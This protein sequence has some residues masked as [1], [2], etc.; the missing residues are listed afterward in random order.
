MTKKSQNDKSNRNIH[1]SFVK[2]ALS[3]KTVAKEFF[4]TNLPQEILSQVDL[5]TLRQEKESYLDNTLG[6][7]IVDLI[8]S[9]KF[10]E[11]K[12]YLILLLEH[13]ST[14]D[15]KMPL[16]IQKYVLR[17]CDDWLKKNKGK[18]IPLIY[19]ILFYSGKEKYTA[20]LSFYSLFNNAEKAKEFLTKPIQIVETSKFQKEDIRSKY[21][22]GLMMYFMNKVHERDI[23]PFLKG[24]IEL[25]RKISEEGD[26]EYI[27]SMLYYVIEKADTEKVEGIF[28]EFKKAVTIKHQE[29]VMTIA[30]RLRE[31]GKEVG[32]QI[33]I[34]KGIEK[35]RQEG[36][37][38]VVT[39]MLLKKLDE[40]IIAESTGLTLEEIK[41]LKNLRRN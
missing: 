41:N 35:G 20:P 3:N 8:Y 10:G 12:G 22:S 29:V 9:V 27:E 13:Q 15:Y 23:F 30:E 5:S 21:Y 31:Q 14:Q 11:D 7:G 39:N 34:E 16:R 17:I 18:K 37:R 28:S 1:D 24:V 4:E 26:I 40:Q 25:I 36:I 32:I 33:G 2:K 6:Y 38:K 19:P